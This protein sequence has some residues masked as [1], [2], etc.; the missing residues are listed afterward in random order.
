MKFIA[1][2][3]LILT[4]CAFS[5]ANIPLAISKV[6]EDQAMRDY[7]ATVPIEFVAFPSC[8]GPELNTS[9]GVIE[10]L[11]CYHLEQNRIEV[12][13]FRRNQFGVLE[14]RYESDM[15]ETVLHELTHAKQMKEYG[16]VWHPIE[17]ETPPK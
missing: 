16:K 11:G 3:V 4:G 15:F 7:L 9:G 10:V 1:L 13:T 8:N 17:Q 12:A 2:A 14:F 6:A 5:E